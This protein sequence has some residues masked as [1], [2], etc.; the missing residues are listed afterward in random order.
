MKK[1]AF[2]LG[3]I[4]TLISLIS[5]LPYLTDFSHLSKYGKGYITGKAIV[6]LVGIALIIFGKKKTSAT[7]Q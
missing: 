2:I 5:M 4:I 6:L 3:I 7:N 1:T